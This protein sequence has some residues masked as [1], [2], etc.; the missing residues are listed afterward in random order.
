MFSSESNLFL[1]NLLTTCFVSFFDL[2]FFFWS[3]TG[4]HPTG[5]EA[6]SDER[7]LTPAETVTG[8]FIVVP[9]GASDPPFS[10]DF[11]RTLALAFSA[12]SFSA[13]RLAI[14]IISSS[15][16]VWTLETASLR[17]LSEPPSRAVIVDCCRLMSSLHPVSF[18]IRR[19][20]SP[21]LPMTTGMMRSSMSTE[22]PSFEASHS[23]THATTASLAVATFSSLPVILIVPE[24]NLLMRS[25]LTWLSDENFLIPDPPF[26]MNADMADSGMSVKM[27]SL[28]A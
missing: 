17:A 15:M 18:W 9:A 5:F 2:P 1:V 23:M 6:N 10:V 3:L 28:R 16:M 20:V 12:C 25:I 13:V 11:D 21:P 22:I 8:G 4:A 27:H 7:S 19:M 24:C 14:W 26:P